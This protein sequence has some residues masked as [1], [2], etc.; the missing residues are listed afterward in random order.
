M[1]ELVSEPSTEKFLAQSWWKLKKEPNNVQNESNHKNEKRETV[2]NLGHLGHCN[3]RSKW[4]LK[5]YVTKQGL[6]IF[7]L[8]FHVLVSWRLKECNLL[9]EWLDKQTMGFFY[10]F[11]EIKSLSQKLRYPSIVSL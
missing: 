6:K 1:L 4:G 3:R 9:D 11:N 7:K 2:N 8:E 10:I 5:W